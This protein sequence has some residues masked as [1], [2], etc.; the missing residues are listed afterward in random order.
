MI[1]LGILGSTQGT[2]LQPLLDA[3]AAGRL[4]ARVAVVIGNREGAGILAR[5]EAHQVPAICIPEKSR[6]IAEDKIQT[7]L[8]AHAVEV[9]LLIGWMRILSG[10]FV[11][12]WSGRIFNVHPSLLP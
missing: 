10:E 1:R 2:S 8:Q 9:V 12:R 4:S 3:I 11:E 7:V 5:A 6:A